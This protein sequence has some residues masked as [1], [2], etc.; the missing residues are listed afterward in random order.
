MR[1]VAD[2]ARFAQRLI[3][4]GFDDFLRLTVIL[5][6]ILLVGVD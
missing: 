3:G 5:L 6:V 4:E 1:L 2:L